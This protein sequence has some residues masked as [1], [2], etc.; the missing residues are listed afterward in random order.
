MRKF[1]KFSDFDYKNAR[2]D[3]N[4]AE[5]TL[6]PQISRE[7]SIFILFYNFFFFKMTGE[8]LPHRTARPWCVSVCV[9]VCLCVSVCL[10]GRLCVCVCVCVCVFVCVCVCLCVS[11]CVCVCLCVSVCVCVCLCV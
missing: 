4:H 11:V 3:W 9:C 10:H 8:A 6:I 2:N 1:S 7:I 5:I